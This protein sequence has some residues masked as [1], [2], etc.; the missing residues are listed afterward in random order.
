MPS[1]D[2]DGEVVE[3]NLTNVKVENWDKT[4][5]TIPSYTLVSNSFRNWKG[6]TQSGGRRIKRSIFIDS[7]TVRFL[8]EEEINR[9]SKINL[10]KN[11]MESKNR[12]LAEHNKN[13]KIEEN[14]VNGR[15]LT[16]I[17]TFRIYIEN[18]LH[19]SENIDKGKNHTCKTASANF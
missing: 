11:Y 16:N 19:S 15:K 1:H 9:L 7:S 17:G 3:I 5:S 13:S 18:Y 10:L 4:I 2:A 14:I 12:E 6:M 8:N